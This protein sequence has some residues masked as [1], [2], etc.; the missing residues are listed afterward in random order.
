[1]KLLHTLFFS[2]RIKLV[3]VPFHASP[4]ETWSVHRQLGTLHALISLLRIKRISVYHNY[5]VMEV[6][7]ILISLSMLEQRCRDRDAG[8]DQY[9]TAGNTAGGACFI[10]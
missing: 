8:A 1:M 10:V 5:R 9:Y 7:E 6:S 4:V 2:V 3:L